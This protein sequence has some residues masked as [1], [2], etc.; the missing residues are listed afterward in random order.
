MRLKIAAMEHGGLTRQLSP[1][2]AL[3]KHHTTPRLTPPSVSAQP[4]LFC[5]PKL[6]S[7]FSGLWV[8]DG[9]TKHLPLSEM[10]TAAL[11]CKPSNKHCTFYIYCTCTYN[12]LSFEKDMSFGAKVELIRIKVILNVSGR[13]DGPFGD[14][15]LPCTCS[16][17][18]KVRQFYT[19]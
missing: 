17:A 6:S 11:S 19:I 8:T 14:L 13:M 7:H 18:E 1:H 4:V 9:F 3:R 15:V 10:C 2:K 12:L 16:R 5:A